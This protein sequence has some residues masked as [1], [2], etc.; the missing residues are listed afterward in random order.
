MAKYVFNGQKINS[1]S[2]M[3][4]LL[5]VCIFITSVIYK[6]CKEEMILLINLCLNTVGEDLTESLNYSIAAA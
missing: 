2:R 4:S 3:F 5:E 6:E 1:F